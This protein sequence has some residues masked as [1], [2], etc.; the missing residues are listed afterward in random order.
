MILEK[1]MER[2][3]RERSR[4]R[5][6]FVPVEEMFT[7][8]ELSELRNAFDA[9]SQG[10]EVVN[11]FSLKALFSEMGIY[12]TDELLDELLRACGKYD[13]ED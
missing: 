3:K 6:Q 5:A 8:Q 7:Q 9:V 4:F 1:A 10:E 2:T 11:M 13:D 12:P